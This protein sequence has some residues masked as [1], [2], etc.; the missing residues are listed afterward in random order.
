M[1]QI[2]TDNVFGQEPYNTPCKEDQKGTP[3]AVYG[4]TNYMESKKNIA[5]GCRYIIIRTAWLY[6]KF[7]KK[8]CKIMMNLTATNPHLKVVFD[9]VNTPTYIHGT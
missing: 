5:T 2:S 6:S 9:Q 7:G 1:V 4:M 8:F 3:T